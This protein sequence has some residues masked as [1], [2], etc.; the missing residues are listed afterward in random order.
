MTTIEITMET[1]G[2]TLAPEWDQIQVSHSPD[3]PLVLIQCPVLEPLR[4]NV[5][6]ED[7]TIVFDC[8]TVTLRIAIESIRHLIAKL[9]PDVAH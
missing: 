2:L 1:L 4:L 6:A 9:P 5:D 3:S 7:M 8:Q